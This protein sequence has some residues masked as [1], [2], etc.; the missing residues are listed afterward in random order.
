MLC[1]HLFYDEM[2]IVEL[3]SLKP[4]RMVEA[5][6]QQFESTEPFTPEALYAVARLSR[7][8]FR[9]FLRYILLA[10]ELWETTPERVNR[11]M[12]R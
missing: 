8:I 7:G 10:I 9:R 2:R 4:E 5:Y 1:G 12:L 6:G 11:S 3:K